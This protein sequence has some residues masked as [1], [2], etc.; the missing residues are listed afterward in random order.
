MEDEAL[1]PPPSKSLERLND[2]DLIS[3]MDNEKLEEVSEES[4]AE[5]F[6]LK[7][8]LLEE[9]SICEDIINNNNK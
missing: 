9:E 8:F 4:V 6:D 7:T 1:S 5:F 3:Q 2:L